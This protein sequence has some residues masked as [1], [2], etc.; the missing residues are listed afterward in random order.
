MHNT[1]RDPFLLSTPAIQETRFYE[2]RPYFPYHKFK[3]EVSR[4]DGT[5]PMRLIFK[6]NNFFKFQNTPVE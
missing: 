3:M 2:P 4:F 5:V 1:S 6:I